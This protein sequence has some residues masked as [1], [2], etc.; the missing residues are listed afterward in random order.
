MPRAPPRYDADM[1]AGFAVGAAIFSALAVG[2][3]AC[4][5]DDDAARPEP[6]RTSTPTSTPTSTAGSGPAD[7]VAGRR[8]TAAPATTTVEPT[9]PRAS[10]DPPVTDPDIEV[11][12][13]GLA[14]FV[15][16]E[17]EP[18]WAERQQTGVIRPEFVNEPK[19]ISFL[20]T[21]PER[22][23][24]DESAALCGWAAST[25]FA[26]QCISLGAFQ[27]GIPWGFPASSV[28]DDVFELWLTSWE[29]G[30]R[31]IV[32][33]A[34]K[35]E[36]GSYTIELRDPDA[37]IDDIITAPPGDDGNYAVLR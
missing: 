28:G 33:D 22:W 2:S 25:A 20:F 12:Q 30:R 4:S 5:G 24:I 26:D 13:P 27:P 19:D 6:R 16:I 29:W 1:R 21:P 23:V 3:V 15:P 31:L 32:I 17:G 35:L 34:T 36:P 9:T 18:D 37:S 11:V 7:T 14:Q 8:P 10:V